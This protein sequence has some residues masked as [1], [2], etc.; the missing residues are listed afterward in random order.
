[1]TVEDPDDL[2]AFQDVRIIAVAASALLC[3]IGE[4]RVWL[5]RR[6]VSGK[7]WCTGD[8]GKLFVRRW[9]ARDRQLIVTPIS[10]PAADADPSSRPLR[11]D[12]HAVAHAEPVVRAVT[13]TRH[14]RP[15]SPA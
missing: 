1:M 8:R 11:T 13:P 15:V 12:L 14:G 4:K 5:P 6:H 7:L 2:V 3:G 9:V 10:A